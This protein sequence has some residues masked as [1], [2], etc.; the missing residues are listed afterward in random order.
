MFAARQ[1]RFDPCLRPGYLPACLW[2]PHMLVLYMPEVNASDACSACSGLCATCCWQNVNETMID[3]MGSLGYDLQ[4]FGRFDVGAGATCSL[5]SNVLSLLLLLLWQL[6]LLLFP[7]AVV[8]V[9]PPIAITKAAMVWL[10]ARP[11][12]LLGHLLFP[13]AVFACSF[14]LIHSPV[15][16][17]AGILDDYPGTSGDGF[18]VRTGPRRVCCWLWAVHNVQYLWGLARHGARI[19]T[20]MS[21]TH[22]H[23]LSLSSLS[24]LSPSLPLSLPSLSLSLSLS[25]RSSV[26]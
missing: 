25:R 20:T 8:A 14:S 15:A 17:S 6:Q 23:T 2:L 13:K 11:L 10:F 24:S 4:L 7:G 16:V 5:H 19:P 1:V 22:T 3:L 12:L 9:F 21:L 18:H 26:S